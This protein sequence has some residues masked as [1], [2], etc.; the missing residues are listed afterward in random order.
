MPEPKFCIVAILLEGEFP[1][2]THKT[3]FLDKA[4]NWVSSEAD[5]ERFERIEDTG[6]V[7]FLP[8]SHNMREIDDIGVYEIGS[9]WLGP[10]PAKV[11]RLAS[12]SGL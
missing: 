9:P 10:I 3:V 6:K 7:G 1:C 12:R 11:H 8:P 5:A 4:R 2:R